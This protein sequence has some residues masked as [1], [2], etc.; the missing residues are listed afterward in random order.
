MKKEFCEPSLEIIS[1]SFEDVIVTSN[2][3]GDL[4]DFPNMFDD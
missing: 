1:T 2:E 4:G 3:P